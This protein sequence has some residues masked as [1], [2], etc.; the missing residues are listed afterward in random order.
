MKYINL[1]VWDNNYHVTIEFSFLFFKWK[2]IYVSG[3]E[4]IPGMFEWWRD[5]KPCSNYNVLMFLDKC[6]KLSGK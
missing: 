4:E 5:N 3:E 2:R 1:F 6:V